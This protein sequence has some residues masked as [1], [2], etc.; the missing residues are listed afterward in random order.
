MGFVE[1]FVAL[2][3]RDHDSTHEHLLA[4]L[5]AIC[6]GHPT[7][8]AEC[9]RPEFLLRQLLENR[10]ESFT[11]QE[12]FQVRGWFWLDKKPLNETTLFWLGGGWILPGVIGGDI[13]QGRIFGGRPIE[14][15]VRRMKIQNLLLASTVVLVS[16]LFG[17]PAKCC[18]R[19]AW[20]S[21]WSDALRLVIWMFV[22]VKDAQHKSYFDIVADKIV[23]MFEHCGWNL[24]CCKTLKKAR[25]G[26]GLRCPMRLIRS[27]CH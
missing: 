1:Q 10:M 15:V 23:V 24:S 7:A 9:R 27:Y 20:R 12:E 25:P 11:G 6:E 8:L 22:Y 3:Q 13:Q 18:P 19:P 5:L 4:A 14:P 26:V 2:L 16:L 21:A 17:L